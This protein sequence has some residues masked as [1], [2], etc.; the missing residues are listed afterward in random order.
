MINN[1][2][3]GGQ[4]TCFVGNVWFKLKDSLKGHSSILE[5]VAVGGSRR[6]PQT[7]G[8][9]TEDFDCLVDR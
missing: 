3:Q 1:C 5:P 8:L 6:S 9:A 2:P 4:S 7:Q